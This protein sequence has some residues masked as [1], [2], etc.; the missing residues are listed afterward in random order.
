MRYPGLVLLLCVG[1][2][3]GDGGGDSAADAAVAVDAA[4]TI[5]AASAADAAATDA[6]DPADAGAN[7]AAPSADADPNACHALGFGAPAVVLEQVANLPTMT[8]GTIAPGAYDAV[9][10]KMITS[11]TNGG[12]RGSWYFAGDGTMQLLE[13]LTLSGTPPTPVP[14]TLSWS[15]SNT[16][17]SRQQTCG[18]S[19]A[20]SNEYTVRVDGA[21]TFLDVRQN[22]VMFTFK[23]R[24]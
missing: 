6:G 5:D 1:I 23:K 18:G 14:R 24:P 4:V 22:T 16:T 7:D 8:G 2:G 17:L 20:F 12:Y 10:L 11:T 3:C 15:T 21:D 13:Q 19:T 9:A